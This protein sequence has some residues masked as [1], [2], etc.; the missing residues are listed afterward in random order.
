MLG[1]DTAYVKKVL[2]NM[3]ENV[4]ATKTPLNLRQRSLAFLIVWAK[5]QTALVTWQVG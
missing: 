3:S 5:M 1:R 2:H 4:I